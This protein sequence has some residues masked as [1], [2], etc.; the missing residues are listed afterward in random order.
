MHELNNDL[1][2]KILSKLD[3]DTRR[4]LNIYSK[5]KIP[6]ELE[7]KLTQ[8]VNKLQRSKKSSYVELGPL[9]MIVGT[10]ERQPIY[11]LTR[12]NDY[13]WIANAP[14][15]FLG[16][17]YRLIYT[18]NEIRSHDDGTNVLEY[19]DVDKTKQT[20]YRRY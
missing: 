5:L 14:V 12:T 10:Y 20:I 19:L 15:K 3:I 17:S 18:S 4:T 2:L 7:H 1:I 11:V 6:T 8:V 9:R 13:E 16:V